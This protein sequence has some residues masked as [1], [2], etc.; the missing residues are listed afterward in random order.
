[1]AEE[2]WVVDHVPSARGARDEQKGGGAHD[3]EQ[4]VW[5]QTTR[6]WGRRDD[7]LMDV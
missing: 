4:A 3:R 6:G 2:G 7:P 1:M 5:F